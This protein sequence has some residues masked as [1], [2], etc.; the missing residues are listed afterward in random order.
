M[1][2]RFRVVGGIGE[3]IGA[4]ERPGPGPGGGQAGA[5]AV[6]VLYTYTSLRSRWTVTPMANATIRISEQSRQ[7]LRELAAQSGQTMQAVADRAIEEYRRQ[8]FLEAVNADYAAL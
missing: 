1:P 7:T 5:R 6:R 3:P 8:R 2:T 4:G